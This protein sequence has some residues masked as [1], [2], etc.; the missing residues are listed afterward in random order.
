MKPLIV[1]DENGY[2][3]VAIPGG[4]EVLR[5]ATVLDITV[6]EF[7]TRFKFNLTFENAITN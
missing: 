4:T 1:P 7:F 6:T 3:P 5:S 2:Y